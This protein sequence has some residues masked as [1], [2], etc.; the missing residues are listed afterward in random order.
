MGSNIFVQV[1]MMALA[2]L[3][4]GSLC[5]YLAR[6]YQSG[7]I[8]NRIFFTACAVFAVTL[9]GW[10]GWLLALKSSVEA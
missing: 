6:L 4:T 9:L 1:V 7:R 2:F 3:L 5:F 10:L 8:S